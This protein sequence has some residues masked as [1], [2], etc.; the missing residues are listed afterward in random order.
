MSNKAELLRDHEWMTVHEA[1]DVLGTGDG[2]VYMGIRRG[3]L[4]AIKVC[5]RGYGGMWLVR[6][7]DVYARAEAMTRPNVDYTVRAKYW[8]KVWR[9]TLRRPRRDRAPC[10]C[11]GCMKWISNT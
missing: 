4:H 9:H 1:A 3:I 10:D 6:G 5:G 2:A 11:R 7:S 8:T